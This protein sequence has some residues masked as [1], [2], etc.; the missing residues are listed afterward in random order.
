MKATLKPVFETHYSTALKKQVS[1]LEQ[2]L[3]FVGGYCQFL[4]HSDFIWDLCVDHDLYDE[5]YSK[6]KAGEE[7]EVSFFMEIEE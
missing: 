6:L 1:T 5:V 2:V 7:V 3:V 4:T